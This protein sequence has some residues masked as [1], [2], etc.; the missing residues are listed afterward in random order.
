MTQLQKMGALIKKLREEKGKSQEEMAEDLNITSRTISRWERGGN[1][2]EVEKL[3]AVADYFNISVDELI[4]GEIKTQQGEKID[5]KEEL[6][7]I[8]SYIDNQ[9]VNKNRKMCIINMICLFS[10]FFSAMFMDA[11]FKFKNSYWGIIQMIF[12]IVTVVMVVLNYLVSMGFSAALYETRKSNKKIFYL[13]I[14]II[15]IVSMM[16]LRWIAQNAY[17][18]F[19]LLENII[20]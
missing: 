19:C 2:G 17:S 14:G 7:T 8:A 12:F 18:Y 10:C 1:I 11:F 3:V 16:I 6:K 20:N 15:I 13:E 5:T 9:N 4:S